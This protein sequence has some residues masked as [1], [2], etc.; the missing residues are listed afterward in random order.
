VNGTPRE[1][2]VPCHV[3]AANGALDDAELDAAVKLARELSTKK[4]WSQAPWTCAAM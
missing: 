3:A 1:A 2:V 4:K